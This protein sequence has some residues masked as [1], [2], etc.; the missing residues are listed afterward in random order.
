MAFVPDILTSGEFWAAV[1]ALAAVGGLIL[2]WWL[3]RRRGEQPPTGRSVDELPDEKVFV[4]S[5]EAAINNARIAISLCL[6]TV[7]ASDANWKA[8]KI[9]RALAAARK[10]GLTVRVLAGT[11]QTQLPGA[12]ELQERNDIDV[13][14]NPEM[15]HS[16]L[17]F[18]K[19][20][21]VDTLVG[22]ADPTP[23]TSSY[24]PSHSWAVL[25][26]TTL[27]DALE[28]EFQRLWISSA[29]RDLYAYCAEYVAPLQ[30]R[31]PAS[32]LAHDLGLP[33]PNFLSQF[34]RRPTFDALA[35]NRTFIFHGKAG[36]GK[37]TLMRHLSRRLTARRLD[38]EDFVLPLVFRYGNENVF[39]DRV[40]DLYRDVL[41]HAAGT[42]YD[43]IETGSEFPETVL[44]GLFESIRRRGLTP[45]LVYC[46]VAA[47]EAHLRNSRRARPVPAEVLQ[48]QIVDESLGTF[49][50][51]C[52]EASVEI[53]EV[54]T[55]Q[56]IDTTVAAVAPMLRAG[57]QSHLW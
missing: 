28:R 56:S 46:N 4:D 15:L 5:Q 9:N 19:I 29:A 17:R 45:V 48:Q 43:L 32:K 57:P 16:D 6:H 23:E 44:P 39:G 52:A 7:H 26:T 25:R 24:S 50:Q 42:H 41:E 40:R 13:R 18:L 10:R 53:V 55:E 31:I 2:T 21:A 37:T 11:G 33:D 22:I 30:E 51:I 3:A 47:A 20:D 8:Q 34:Y 38:L 35:G 27:A 36:S 12:Y 54:S 1:T 49:R 14:L